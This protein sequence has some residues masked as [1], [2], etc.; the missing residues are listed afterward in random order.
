MYGKNSMRREIIVGNNNKKKP[1][2][3]SRRGAK[4]FWFNFFHEIDTIRFLSVY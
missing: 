2:D 3:L 4:T 1:N